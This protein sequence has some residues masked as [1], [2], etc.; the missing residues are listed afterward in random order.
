MLTFLPASWSHE[1]RS[2]FLNWLVG[3]AG[4]LI[5]RADGTLSFAH[6]SF[7][8]YLSAWYLHTNIEGDSER[9]EACCQKLGALHWWETLRLWAALVGG[10]QPSK[11]APVMD[12]LLRKGIAGL[13]LTGCMLADGSGPE[14]I[15]R[16]WCSKFLVF[17]HDPWTSDVLLV[18]TAWSGSRQEHRKQMMAQALPDMAQ[19]C[20]W[21]GWMR[22]REWARKVGLHLVMP[23]PRESNACALLEAQ[24]QVISS[25]RHVAVGRILSSVPFWP[26]EPWEL[27]LLQSWPSRR[28]FTGHF[29]QA[30]AMVGFSRNQII[31]LTKRLPH[32]L[33]PFPAEVK[34]PPQFDVD[35]IKYAIADLDDLDLPAQERR[36]FTVSYLTDWFLQ[37]GPLPASIGTPAIW[38]NVLQSTFRT[39][40]MGREWTRENANIWT[41]ALSTALASKTIDTESP[42]RRTG[43]AFAGPL[44]IL[45]FLACVEIGRVSGPIDLIS[46]ACRIALNPGL[47]TRHFKKA[48]RLCTEK[49]DPLWPMLARHLALRG[50]R[51]DQ[52][53]LCALAASPEQRDGVLGW[54]LKYIVRGDVILSDGSELTLDE[55]TSELGLKQLPYL[56]DYPEFPDLPCPD[57]ETGWARKGW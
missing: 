43:P 14:K 55:L 54:G 47:S 30:A 39:E 10:Q 1:Q 6:L 52:S 25:P 19:N 32:L 4:L 26:G 24:Y 28:R 40:C 5:D 27:L 31:D 42:L 49:L 15:F 36:C 9:T 3:P 56:E 12:A 11:I 48:L 17:T 20:D 29:L 13:S 34:V 50:T 18:L 44:G 23:F 41:R 38:V 45:A 22:L 53:R 46:S 8:E 33:R 37:I 35:S 7:Q 16:E 2:R 57:P 21:F 51:G